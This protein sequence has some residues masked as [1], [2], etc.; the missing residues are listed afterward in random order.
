MKD[1]QAWEQSRD[2]P[3]MLAIFENRLRSAM[4]ARDDRAISRIERKICLYI[5]NCW[6]VV[7]PIVIGRQAQ[8]EIMNAPFPILW[9]GEW[10]KKLAGHTHS[11]KASVAA[12]VVREVFR[13]PFRNIEFRSEWRTPDARACALAAYDDQR[14]DGTLDPARLAITADA[15]EE[16]GADSLILNHLREPVRHYRGCWALDLIMENDP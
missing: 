10:G 15:L 4:A 13:N 16:A 8:H 12:D 3:L 11:L 1:A 2:P 6:L 7:D 14:K 5:I 9:A